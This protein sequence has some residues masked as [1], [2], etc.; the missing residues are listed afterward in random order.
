MT[1]TYKLNEP[2]QLYDW[3]DSEVEGA[4]AKLRADGVLLDRYSPLQV[5]PG[6]GLCH[7][8]SRLRAC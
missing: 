5:G 4:T 8:L 1:D 6:G 7:P 2:T 3:L